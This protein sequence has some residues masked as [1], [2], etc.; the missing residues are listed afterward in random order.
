MTNLRESLQR[1]FYMSL[2]NEKQALRKSKREEMLNKKR[3]IEEPSQNTEAK[4][5]YNEAYIQAALYEV[6][7]PTTKNRTIDALFCLR[8]ISPRPVMPSLMKLLDSPDENIVHDTLTVFINWS[9]TDSAFSKQIFT[10]TTLPIFVKLFDNSDEK[11]QSQ[12]AWVVGNVASEG[13]AYKQVCY[14]TFIVRLASLINHSLS[15]TTVRVVVFS[16][17]CLLISKPLLTIKKMESLL[18]LLV[19]VFDCADYQVCSDILG[20]FVI[21]SEESDEEILTLCSQFFKDLFK[22]YLKCT[23]NLLSTKEMLL[24]KYFIKYVGNCLRMEEDMSL[25]KEIVELNFI[26]WMQDVAMFIQDPSVKKNC[27]WV[28][29][30][31]CSTEYPNICSIINKKD[32]MNQVMLCINTEQDINCKAMAILA[33]CNFFSVCDQDQFEKLCSKSLFFLTTNRILQERDPRTTKQALLGLYRMIRFMIISNIPFIEILDTTGLY[34][35]LHRLYETELDETSKQ[36]IIMILTYYEKYD[37]SE[38]LDEE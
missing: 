15:I 2:V 27:F 3:V 18:T 38:N 25:T 1:S 10:P 12:I 19:L 36:Y 7:H 11:I 32:L 22:G 28:I 21:C 33:F 31:L 17:V 23:T 13:G 8:N 29:G 24:A 37:T 34:N 30:N 6:Q 35:S 14:N 9:G 4:D 16:I 20:C 26:K 5:L